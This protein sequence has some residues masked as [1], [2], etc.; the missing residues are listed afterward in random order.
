MPTPVR[1]RVKIGEIA[2]TSRTD[3]H[4]A[5]PVFSFDKE[6]D[7]YEVFCRKVEERVVEGLRNY[8]IKTIR[9]DTGVYIKPSRTARQRDCVALTAENFAPL[10]ASAYTNYQKRT[11]DS[12]PF[13][14]EMFVLAARKERRVLPG[15]RHATASWVQEAATTT[16]NYLEERP[17]LQ[18][19]EIFRTH[20]SISRYCCRT[21]IHCN[22][23]AGAAYRRRVS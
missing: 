15:T 9:P 12:G 3:V 8:R 4:V 14:I 1:L 7:S 6:C 13:E 23:C 11:K 22:I 10:I 17:D 5:E 20:G 2:M 19:G 16:D 21:P 18:V